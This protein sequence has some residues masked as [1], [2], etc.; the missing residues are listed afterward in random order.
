MQK[1]GRWLSPMT[2]VSDQ[3]RACKPVAIAMKRPKLDTTTVGR[4]LQ[5]LTDQQFIAFFYEHL[6]E[7]HIYREERRYQESHLVLANATRNREDDG[8]VDAWQL[9]LLC[10]T[11]GQNWTAD[12]PV[13]QFGTHCD[14]QTAS[15]ARISQCPICANEVS[16]T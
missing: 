7:R 10:P 16:G 6:T 4:W 2:T 8:T 11:P 9:Q 14:H 3:K 13:C 15:V 12:A 5:D 1:A